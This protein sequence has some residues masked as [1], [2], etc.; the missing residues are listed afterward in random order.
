MLMRALATILLLAPCLAWA[1][2]P[3]VDGV[4]PTASDD[5]DPNLIIVRERYDP[6]KRIQSIYL[7]MA[8]GSAD[9]EVT[10]GEL[11]FSGAETVSL[12]TERNALKDSDAE[13]GIAGVQYGRNRGLEGI[14]PSTHEPIEDSELD[15]ARIQEESVRF[16]FGCGR[17]IDDFRIL[18]RYPPENASAFL[19]LVLYHRRGPD[20][21]GWPVTNDGGLQIGSIEDVQPDDGLYPN[22]VFSIENLKLRLEDLDIVEDS[23]TLGTINFVGG[24][25]GPGIMTVENGFRGTDPDLDNGRDQNGQLTPIPITGP[26]S[27]LRYRV[28]PLVGPNGLQIP[29]SGIQVLG[30]PRN[31]DEGEQGIG[32]ISVDAPADLPEGIYAG[33]IT[34]WEDN[35]LDGLEGPEEPSDRVTVIV[36]VLDR[37]DAEVDAEI[38]DAGLDAELDSALDAEADM[39]V[40]VDMTQPDAETDDLGVDL[41]SSIGDSETMDGATTPDSEVETDGGRDDA[42]ADSG[43]ADMSA[44]GN[45]TDAEPGDMGEELDAVSD[46]A[47]VAVPRSWPGEVQGGALLCTQTYTSPWDMLLLLL[48]W[49]ILRRRRR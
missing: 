14:D 17:D 24:A 20:V 30:L 44:D 25:V 18:I 28:R 45:V 29:T 27:H 49:P 38:V 31:L 7:R 37:L 8:D 15:V 26:L 16:W 23:V 4:F 1:Q 35:D 3:F 2:T 22:E 9:Y 19:D 43:H 39:A 41:D 12:I 42:S 10:S 21:E 6:E 46:S 33:D 47:I 32:R 5:A 34:V 36:E 48:L 11:F 13:W 40:E